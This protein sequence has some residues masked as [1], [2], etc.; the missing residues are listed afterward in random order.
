MAT[1]LGGCITFLRMLHQSTSPDLD[2]LHAFV[3]AARTGSFSAAG[4]ALG[5][6]SSVISRKVSALEQQAGVRLFERTTRRMKLT[7]GGELYLEQVETAL[8]MLASAQD[9]LRARTSRVHGTLRISLPQTFGRMY[10]TGLLPSFLK[11]HPELGIDAR[12]SDAYVD[13]VEEGFD[14]AI[15]LGTLV[16]S[17]VVARRV[18]GYA[19]RVFAAP[20]LLRRHGVPQRPEDFARIPAIGYAGFK[21]PQ[22]WHLQRGGE[23]VSVEVPLLLKVDDGQG[24]VQAAEAG[25]GLLMAADWLAAPSVA[26]GRLVEVMPAWSDGEKRQIH[27]VTP[28]RRGL[29]A[30]TREFTRWIDQR[31]R[32]ALKS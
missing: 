5:R 26:A 17:S 16:D 25:I 20:A 7:E 8:R 6:H 3:T 22:R 1:P 4:R 13:L 10:V 29:P 28:S 2:G 15:R 24:M 9:E 19:H 23:K 27:I 30:K 18:M 21:Y 14:L 32:L 31:L 11:E 12:L